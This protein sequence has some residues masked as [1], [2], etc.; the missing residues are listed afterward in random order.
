MRICENH[1]YLI[2]C[3]LK[4]M[5]KT[6]RWTCWF[7][8]FRNR[9]STNSPTPPLSETDSFDKLYYGPMLYRRMTGRRSKL[10]LLFEEGANSIQRA[11]KERTQNL[12]IK[13]ETQLMLFFCKFSVDKSSRW[14]I[15]L[16]RTALRINPFNVTFYLLLVRKFLLNILQY[17]LFHPNIYVNNFV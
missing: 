3:I 13:G 6:Y 5:Y 17:N 2:A 16:R 10:D 1:K 7:V 9:P 12:H 4:Q 11:K 8:W 14:I 15:P